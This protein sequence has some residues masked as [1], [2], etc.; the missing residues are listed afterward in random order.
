MTL[1][2][3][4]AKDWKTLIPSARH[5]ALM[6]HHHHHPFPPSS[7]LNIVVLAAGQGTRMK[8]QQPKVLQ[9]LAGQPL[10]AHVLN[11][12][13]AL[14]PSQ[15]IVVTGHGSP[16][17]EA[18]VCQHPATRALVSWRCVE[19]TER[20]GTGHAVQQAIPHLQDGI[21]LVL[22]GDVPLIQAASLQ[23]LLAWAQAG[24]MALLSV[25]FED[26][27][28]YGRIVRDEQTRAVQ[29][30]V[31][32]KD[33]SPTERAIQECYSGILACPTTSF[34]H[35]LRQLTNHNA[36]GE[37]YLT[38]VVALAR[39][40][41]QTVQAHVLEDVWQV[42]GVNT[43]VQLATLER[44][45]QKR[46][47]T[48][49]MEAGVRLADPDRLDVRGELICGQDVFIDV[50]CVFEGRVV[51]GDSVQVASHCVLR[52]VEVEGGTHIEPF[53]HLDGGAC[54]SP[55]PSAPSPIH[56]GKD[57]RIGPFTRVRPGSHL[58]DAVHLGNF[59]E[60]KNSQIGTGSK[61]NHLAYVGDT[62]LG[63]NVNFGAGSITANYDGAHKHHTT[64]ED[65]V[66]VGSHCV[67]VAPLTV[68]QNSTVGA[69]TVLTKDTPPGGLTVGRPKSTH[70]PH[71]Q[72]PRKDK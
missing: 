30:I 52:H 55:S 51:L 68:G 34:I 39:Q 25:C 35:Y 1:F 69:G 67:L 14:N 36:Q 29:A 41:G 57:C 43:P 53:S 8:S 38:D 42:A 58:G 50:N 32:H 61:A 26:P 19:Q 15:V 70:I 33:A 49:L 71:W 7:A 60:V 48:S 63:Q 56:I 5:L 22:Y 4:T 24:E 17:V 66:H 3:Q 54:L 37:F 59:V 6:P 28:G 64:I 72:R 10:L 23:P 47:A 27:S 16:S 9:P 62:T 11:T 21:T 12:A 45:Y 18:L 44:E 40:A 46:L 65:G 31:E 13:A 20:K 2:G